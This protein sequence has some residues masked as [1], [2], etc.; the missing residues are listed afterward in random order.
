MSAK[1][2]RHG[3][4]KELSEEAIKKLQ[5]EVNNEDTESAHGKA[6]DILCELLEKIG[7]EDVIKKYNEVSK[8][9]A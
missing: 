6:D 1:N 7:Y 8:W 4:N 9:Y 3:M 5:K 2:W